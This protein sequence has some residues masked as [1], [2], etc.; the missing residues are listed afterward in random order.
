MSKYIP[1]I[2]GEKVYLSPMFLLVSGMVVLKQHVIHLLLLYF[3]IRKPR[4]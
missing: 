3:P 4:C 1:R 2:V